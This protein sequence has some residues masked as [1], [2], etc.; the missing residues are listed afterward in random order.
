MNASRVLPTSVPVST[1]STGFQKKRHSEA[2][3]IRMPR[4][5]QDRQTS[6]VNEEN[7]EQLHHQRI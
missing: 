3:E 2:G 1:Q 6:H 7:R 4:S 5:E